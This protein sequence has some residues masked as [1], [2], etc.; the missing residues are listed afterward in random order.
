MSELSVRVMA[1]KYQSLLRRTERIH[2]SYKKAVKLVG[3][4]K[5]LERLM[6][7]EKVRYSKP[8]GNPNT[9]WR[10]NLGDIIRNV[11]PLT[12]NSQFCEILSC[13]NLV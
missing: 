12:G 3:G 10:F 1:Q 11:K 7:E 8:V 6:L 5:R 9:M 4:E 2:V 13:E